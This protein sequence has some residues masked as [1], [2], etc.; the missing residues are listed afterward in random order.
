M[1]KVVEDPDILSFPE[2]YTPFL[3]SELMLIKNLVAIALN[4]M[5]LIYPNNMP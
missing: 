4:A 5:I 2:S 1:T 3:S